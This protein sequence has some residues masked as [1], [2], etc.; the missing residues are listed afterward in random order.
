MTFIETVGWHTFAWHTFWIIAFIVV[1]NLFY[2]FVKKINE[3]TKKKP[4]NKTQPLTPPPPRFNVGMDVKEW[5][6]SLMNYLE[7]N[8]IQTNK[9]EIL[10]D[11]L[12]PWCQSIL[13]TFR[14]SSD[15]DIAFEQHILLMNKLFQIK[16]KQTQKKIPT[17]IVS[18]T[19]LAKKTNNMRLLIPSFSL[20]LEKFSSL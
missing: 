5:T 12:E 17:T 8:N 19:C 6:E 13:K 7:E 10:L 4:S 9:H 16:P 18:T 14:F 20:E 2:I 1:I 11:K 15:L 3:P